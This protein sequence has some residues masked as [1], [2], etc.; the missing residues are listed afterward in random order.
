MAENQDGQEKSQEPTAKRIADAREK[1][2]VPRSRELNTTAIT[3]IG[4]AGMM[5][6]APRFTEGFHKLFEQQFVLDRADIFDPNAMLGHLVKAIGDALFMLLPF[7]A[8]MVGVAVLSSI[9]LG[10]FNVSLQAM[11]PKLSKLDPI[12]GMKR[13]FSVKGLME[14]VKSLGKFLL[15]AVATIVLLKVWAGDLIRLGDLDVEQSLGQAMS[16]VAWSALL[17]SST[18]ILMA[19]I[20]VPFQLWQHRR[21][22]KMTQQEVREEYKETEGKPEVKG[23]IRQMQRE[24]A[25]RRMMAEVPQ[26]DVI[27]T[28]PTHYAVALR[29][30]PDR[31]QA[32]LVVAKGK[33]LIAANIRDIGAAHQVP[34]IEAPVLARAIY[35]NTEINQQIPAALFLAVAQL[36]AYVFQLHAYREGGGDI[37]QPPEEYPVPEE[38]RHD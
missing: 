8:L 9:A 7:F 22:L 33:N 35:F 28:N 1:G 31:M 24:I 18:L 3:M 13:I 4:L 29:Y 27:V 32:P 15:V 17:L 19:L 36:L 5:V 30:D 11:Q 14:M 10:G 38:M 2:Q 26:A 34:L 25:Q 23:R 16:L 21:D 12:K 20:D 37:P 6:M